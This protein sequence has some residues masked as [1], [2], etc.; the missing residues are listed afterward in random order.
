MELSYLVPGRTK[1][2]IVRDPGDNKI[3]AAAIEGNADYI[4][5]RDRDLLDLNDYQRIKII[6]PEEF[7]KIL[8]SP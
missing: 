8:R 4:V 6:K 2:E 7:M 1:V 3:I 5:S